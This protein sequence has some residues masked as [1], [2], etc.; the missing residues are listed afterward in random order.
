MGYIYHFRTE[1]INNS[2]YSD[3]FHSYSSR[4][5]SIAFICI[6][7]Q[8]GINPA[9]S[10]LK[11]RTRVAATAICM[12]TLGSFMIM[13]SLGI[14]KSRR[15]ARSSR[16]T[17]QLSPRSPAIAVSIRLSLMTCEMI[18]NGFAPNARRTPI[19]FVRSLTARQ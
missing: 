18:S 1:L 19:S 14:A 8:A 5:A 16:K 6:A 9:N 4:N 12:F 10:P 2:T 11:R 15:L 3:R 13:L 17:P 7:R